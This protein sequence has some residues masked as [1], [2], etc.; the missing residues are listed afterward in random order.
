MKMDA[1]LK[2][3]VTTTILISKCRIKVGVVDRSS[4][5]SMDVSSDPLQ[6]FS[7]LALQPPHLWRRVFGCS[8]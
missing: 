7:P 5:L 2:I 6:V 3:F 4:D 8:I 1:I